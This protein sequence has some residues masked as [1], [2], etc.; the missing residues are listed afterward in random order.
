VPETFDLQSFS[1]D[2]APRIRRGTPRGVGMG[3]RTGIFVTLEGGEGSGKTTQSRRIVG[4]LRSKGREALETREPG[5]TE[6]GE[7]V[8]DVLLHRV[9]QLTPRAELALYLASRAQLVEEVVRPALAAGRDVVCDRF[10]DSSVAYQGGGRELGIELVERLNDWAT[11]GIVP[12]LTFY[13]DVKPSEG[14]ARRGRAGSGKLDRMEREHLAFHEK[15]RAAYLELAER[16]PDRFRV[17][18]TGGGEEDVWQ[19]VREA[20]EERLG[21]VGTEG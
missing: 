12:D 10:A 8:R 20:L 21:R 18:P 4:Y 19:R 2:D 14:L 9:R 15:V 17:I 16:Y 11:A 5:G 1:R 6:A 13:F 7:L 3:G